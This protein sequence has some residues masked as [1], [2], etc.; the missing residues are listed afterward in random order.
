MLV[1]KCLDPFFFMLSKSKIETDKQKI[2]K[3]KEN[4]FVLKY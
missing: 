4:I 3:Q 2:N 1:G